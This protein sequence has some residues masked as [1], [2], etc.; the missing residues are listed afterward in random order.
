MLIPEIDIDH[1]KEIFRVLEGKDW[2]ITKL[3]EINLIDLNSLLSGFIESTV[4]LEI[5][6]PNKEYYLR[7]I[8]IIGLQKSTNNQSLLNITILLVSNLLRVLSKLLFSS[9]E[10]IELG[11]YWVNKG[12]EMEDPSSF[13]FLSNSLTNQC[14]ENQDLDYAMK[15]TG[16]LIT[17]GSVWLKEHISDG[18]EYI[19]PIVKNI[20]LSLLNRSKILRLG[21]IKFE[22][23]HG[24]VEVVKMREKFLDKADLLIKKYINNG[25][26][27][28]KLINL[29]RER[30]LIGKNIRERSTE[31][32]KSTIRQSS[33]AKNSSAQNSGKK[34]SN[35]QFRVRS[36]S[37]ERISSS[38]IDSVDGKIQTPLFASTIRSNPNIPKKSYINII[39]EIEELK[40]AM[41][42][43]FHG[44]QSQTVSVLNSDPTSSEFS[45]LAIR[46]TSLESAHKSNQESKIAIQKRLA[47]LSSSLAAQSP[48]NAQSPAP[49][50]AP[51]I[52]KG[53]RDRTSHFST[54]V[55]SKTNLDAPSMRELRSVTRANSR[56]LTSKSTISNVS[57]IIGSVAGIK[58]D[59]L[60]NSFRV[61]LGYAIGRLKKSKPSAEIIRKKHCNN[62]EVEFVLRKTEKGGIELAIGILEVKEDG[63]VNRL[64]DELLEEEQIIYLFKNISSKDVLPNNFPISTFSKLTH[65]INFVLAHFIVV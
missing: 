22:K 50:T 58:G 61:Y 14:I 33:F 43:E 57:R 3:S 17:L 42:N 4:Y 11:K 64:F 46:L 2:I 24:K 47:A 18:K 55:G 62:K 38:K 29:E 49:R 63:K 45:H 19:Q 8:E 28:I 36:S 9:K 41:L 16:D 52:A 39:K 5:T 37:K 21:F 51:V 54:I 15:L 44:L 48:A 30:T 25:D 12:R 34:N 32:I 65:F 23:S 31:P 26:E 10:L 53:N 40:K 1:V 59:V 13:A 6:L 20:S 7:L 27:M 60:S 56:K 35:S